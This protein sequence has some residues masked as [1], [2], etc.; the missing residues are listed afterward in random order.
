MSTPDPFDL[1]RFVSAQAGV[2]ERACRELLAGR[3]ASHWMWFVFPQICGLGYSDRS[4]RYAINSLEEAQ[5]YLAHPILGP[6]LRECIELVLSHADRSA[7][8]IFGAPDDTKFRS[9][10]T[11]FSVASGDSLF[12][13]GLEIFFDGS[14]DPATLSLLGKREAAG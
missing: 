8:A 7:H 14:P 10:L 9:C 4:I 1:A 13:R 3:K 6:R 2:H 11:L 12:A 5:A